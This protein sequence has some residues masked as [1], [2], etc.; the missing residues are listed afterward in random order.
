MRSFLLC[1]FI[2]GSTLPD[3]SRQQIFVTCPNQPRNVQYYKNTHS[4]IRFRHD[5]SESRLSHSW[6][7]TF[8]DCTKNESPQS[9]LV[10]F[11]VSTI[12]NI[13]IFSSVKKHADCVQCEISKYLCLYERADDHVVCVF[14]QKQWVNNTAVSNL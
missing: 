2:T 10:S 3:G 8:T 7:C 9:V 1:L 11:H 4:L 5:P 6:C 12:L 13:E 14:I